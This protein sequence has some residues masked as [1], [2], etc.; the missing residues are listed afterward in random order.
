MHGLTKFKTSG[1]KMMVKLY[2]NHAE[3][4]VR[5]WSPYRGQ[6]QLLGLIDNQVV[7]IEG[8]FLYRWQNQ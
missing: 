5:F 6:N 1:K 7:F 2:C 3:K 4:V 8:W